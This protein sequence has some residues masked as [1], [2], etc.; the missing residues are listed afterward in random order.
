MTFESITSQEQLDEIIGG[1]VARAREKAIAET[2]AKFADYSDLKMRAEA[3]ENEAKDTQAK[4]KEA[5]EARDALEA[6]ARAHEINSV[7]MR[8]AHEAGLPLEFADRLTGS[9]EEE[10]KHD[11]QI[12]AGFVK[13]QNKKAPIGSAEA[14]IGGDTI[15]N[16]FKSM[17]EQMKGE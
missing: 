11:A 15:S 16:G 9:T 12:L 2:E 6:K 3:L 8:I 10:I 14:P 5:L 4:L 13:P 7:K 1:R 17:L